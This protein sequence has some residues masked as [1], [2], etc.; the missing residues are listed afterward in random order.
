V[1]KIRTETDLKA[2]PEDI[3]ED[4]EDQKKFY[5]YTYYIQVNLSAVNGLKV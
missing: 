1:Q 5:Q 4:I 3:L 2:L